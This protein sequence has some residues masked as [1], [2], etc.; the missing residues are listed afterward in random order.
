MILEVDQ[1][2][3]RPISPGSLERMKQEESNTL[4]QLEPQVTEK[5]PLDSNKMSL[6]D[7]NKMPSDSDPS[8]LT[9]INN[10]NNNVELQHAT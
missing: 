9:A 1:I 3:L 10:N 7:P 6:L 8:L 2:H 4:R 5:L